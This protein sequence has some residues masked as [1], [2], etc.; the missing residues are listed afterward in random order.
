MAATLPSCAQSFLDDYFARVAR[1][2]AEQPH[3]VTPVATVTPRLEQELRFDAMR[4]GEATGPGG[5]GDPLWNIDGG[6]GLEIIP[7]RRIELLFNAP[8]ELIHEGISSPHDGLGDVS[9]LGKFRI[10][11]A[12]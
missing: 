7:L 1:N 3:W 4:N 6:K 8:P 9:F 11:S 12:N 10:F 5:G 2:Q